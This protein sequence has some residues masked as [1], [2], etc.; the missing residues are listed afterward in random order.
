MANAAKL[1]QLK[2][3]AQFWGEGGQ[4][5][6]DALAVRLYPEE[7]A[8]GLALYQSNTLT[9]T[10]TAVKASAGRLYGVHI[11][12]ATGS[13]TSGTSGTGGSGVLQLYNAESAGST[14]VQGTGTGLA[15]LKDVVWFVTGMARSVLYDPGVVDSTS[16]YGS[17]IS[18]AVATTAAGSTAV[19]T[20]PAVTIV[21]A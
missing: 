2:S 13:G 15:L 7:L 6:A 19:A 16:L 21:Y 11:E 14:L 1:H 12:P 9:T 20:L 10:T 17:G 18:A 5:W 8:D 4:R 3:A